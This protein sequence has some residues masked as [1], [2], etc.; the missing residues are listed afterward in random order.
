[1]I[2]EGCGPRR[3]M[4]RLFGELPN[5]EAKRQWVEGARLKAIMGSC[6]KS[7]KS[8]LCGMRCWC[9]FAQRV[10]NLKGREFPPPLDG[11]LA[12]STLFRC[13]GT[14]SNYL[15]HIRI[16]CELVQ[17]STEV[18]NCAELGRAKRAI[19][20]KQAFM[21]RPR[22][23]VRLAMMQQLIPLM[24]AREE[25]KVWV[26]LYLCTYTFMLR[27]PSECLPITVGAGFG[28]K[29]THSIA[30]KPDCLELWLPYR[31]NRL[32][33]SVLKRACWCR[34]CPISCPVHVL[35]VFFAQYAAG[36][37]PFVGI[38]PEQAR[39]TLRVLLGEAGVS[40]AGTYDTKSLRR[41]HAVDIHKNG[42]R[43]KEI[44]EGGDWR[45]PAFM[46]YLDISELEKDAVSEAHDAFV[47]VMAESSD[48][49]SVAGFVANAT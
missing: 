34:S 3:A 18:F 39:L 22:T 24:L 21:P 8:V 29:S 38:S 27:L 23:F 7:H 37:K 17:C 35:G 44:L 11:L 45:S 20:K 16:A 12:F 41:G 13:R 28:D 26:M 48:D 36:D 6:A 1:M 31:K 4:K 32:Q 30:V 42:G 40:D 46:H 9:K 14:F 47:D 33:S 2:V 49:E 19:E 15:G 43:L 10:L 5:N 25:V